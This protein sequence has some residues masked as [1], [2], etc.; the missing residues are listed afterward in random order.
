MMSELPHSTVGGK[1][2]LVERA[3]VLFRGGL[4]WS[5]DVLER[6]D[7]LDGVKDKTMLVIHHVKKSLQ[8]M[9][10]RWLSEIE[11][12]LDLVGRELHSVY[13]DLMTEKLD[14]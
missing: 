1:K 13:I 7:D 9:T 12:A 8:F 10:R 6:R 4:V 11:Q 2:L 5:S 3:V 14:F